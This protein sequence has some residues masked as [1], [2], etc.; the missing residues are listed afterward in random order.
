MLKLNAIIIVIVVVLEPIIVQSPTFPATIIIGIS[1]KIV[2][3]GLVLIF[4]TYLALTF[5]VGFAHFHQ[6]IFKSEACII[7]LS[8]Y[9]YRTCKPI[10]VI[11]DGKS[12]TIP[13]NF[14]TD[15][16]SI[17]RILWPLLAPQYSG[18]VSASILHDYLYRCNNSI[19]RQFADEVL[20]SALITENVTAFTASKFFLAVRLFG[21]SH[22][23]NGIC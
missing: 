16:A 22:F 8:G 17:P 15:L 4:S 13:P 9:N 3:H 21:D 6:V 11:I 2:R 5:L 7:P 10:K 20:Y 23:T 1:M 12:Y 19:S 14:K 18:F